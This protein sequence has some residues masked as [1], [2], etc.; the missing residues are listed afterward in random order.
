MDENE[1]EKII[2]FTGKSFAVCRWAYGMRTIQDNDTELQLTIMFLKTKPCGK[3][4]WTTIELE[5]YH[6]F[7]D[8]FNPDDE[9]QLTYDISFL[10]TI[11]Q[12]SSVL[13]AKPLPYTKDDGSNAVCVSFHVYNASGLWLRCFASDLHCINTYLN[14]DSA[15]EAIHKYKKGQSEN[16]QDLKDSHNYVWQTCIK[17]DE[18]NTGPLP[19]F[20]E[21]V[22]ARLNKLR[23]NNNSDEDWQ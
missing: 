7:V 11:H 6:H 15:E 5:K 14:N 16:L 2:Q 4:G 21:A 1:R 19:N 8:D 18:K 13:I 12:A 22:E 3:L 10:Y 23:Y 20:V 9:Q 17:D